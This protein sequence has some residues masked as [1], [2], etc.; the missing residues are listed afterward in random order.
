M[1]TIDQILNALQLR[2]D[3]ECEFKS[4]KGGIP[5]SLWETY[6]AMA[7]T[8]GGNIVIGI[9]ETSD[10]RF[11]VQGIDDPLKLEK[12]FWNTINN[13]GKVSI[14]LLKNTDAQFHTLGEKVLFVVNVPQA[15]RRQRPVFL[16]QNPLTGTYRRYND[17]DYKCDAKE[18]QRMLSDQSEL[19]ADS[20]ILP[21]FSIDDL[22][23]DSIKQYRHRVSARTPHH[24]WLRID[25][26][27][28]LA[29]LGGWRHD[30][31]SGQEGLTVAGLLMFGKEDALRTPEN[32]LNFHIDYR[33]RRT[34][35]I[36][37]GWQDRLTPD[38]TWT[39]NLFQFFQKVYPKLVEGLKLPFTYQRFPTDNDHSFSAPVRQGFLPVH[40]AIQ[41]ALVNAIIHADYLGQG[42]VVIER[43]HDRL[44]LTNPGTLLISFEQ[45]KSG[46]ISEC[47]NPSL[48]L[49]FQLLGAG[50]KAG[51]GVDKIRQGWTSQK[52]QYPRVLTSCKPDRIRLVLPMVSLLPETSLAK[53]KLLPG[54]EQLESQEVEALV[55]ADL[56]NNVSNQRLQES[57]MIHTSDIT[58]MLQ[59]LVSKG[60]LI[61]DNYGRWA[62]YRLATDILSN[63]SDNG[64][65]STDNGLNSTCNGEN[66]TGNG[67]DSTDNGIFLDT[68]LQAIS[69]PARKKRRLPPAEMRKIIHRL[70]QER[71]LTLNQICH[72]LN[73]APGT[74]RDQFIRNM[75]SENELTPR[76]TEPN[77]PQQA[78]KTNP[79][80]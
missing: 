29:K 26:R 51:A 23:T 30:R 60:L 47:R 74:V 46:G 73:R 10:G 69:A 75:L 2:E 49:M 16:E 67:A 58:K 6:S 27:E 53:I 76:Y 68:E 40:E 39:P 64:T 19:S 24:P 28:F 61:K 13:R 9:K 25:M 18:V 80:R 45:W 14:N 48:Q 32:E 31:Q 42:G 72:F 66:S 34:N 20:R 78:Y 63:S 8:D 43:F 21:L 52:W 59:G 17:G 70:C 71:Y 1:M 44:E 36:A 79:N 54:F 22:D 62:T 77:H 65:D 33:E 35:S 11:E 12:D 4:G 7:N 56:E 5:G 3:R 50:D 41:E 37:D 57:S 15:Y 38:G 55:I